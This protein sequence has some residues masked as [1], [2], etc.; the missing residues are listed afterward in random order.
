VKPQ[1]EETVWRS[2]VT[3]LTWVRQMAHRLPIALTSN[4]VLLQM[5][6]DSGWESDDPLLVLQ[7]P[8]N[9]TRGLQTD[10][11]AAGTSLS[12]IPPARVD[13]ARAT[14]ETIE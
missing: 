13:V 5:Q 10:L 2:G 3:A 12:V 6:S 7:V 14:T 4:D 11:H 1:L 8:D 9:W